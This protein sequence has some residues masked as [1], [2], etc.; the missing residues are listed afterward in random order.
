[1][2]NRQRT[3]DP[4]PGSVR[5]LLP[6]FFAF[7]LL[8]LLCAPPAVR[9]AGAEPLPYEWSRPDDPESWDNP[10]NSDLE[11]VPF[12]LVNVEGK[13]P[14]IDRESEWN[15]V[16]KPEWPDRDLPNRVTS[17]TMMLY[18]YGM[19][20]K[21][22]WSHVWKKDLQGLPGILPCT[23]VKIAG[24]Y[25]LSAV[26]QYDDTSME[27]S[28]GFTVSGPGKELI[29]DVIE[30]AAAENKVAGDPWQTAFNLYQWLLNQLEYDYTYSYH[31]SDAILRH[32][33]VCDSYARLYF[34]LCRAAGLDAYVIYGD[35]RMAYHAWTAVKIGDKWYYAD[36]TWDDH[37]VNDPAMGEQPAEDGNG[38]RYGV[39]DYRYFMLDRHL[40]TLND[41]LTCTW[42][43]DYKWTCEEQPAVSLDG[44]YYVHTGR[45]AAWGIAGEDGFRTVRDLIREAFVSGEKL[46]SSLSLSGTPLRTRGFTDPPFCLAATELFLLSWDLKG[47]SL[48]LQDGSKVVLDT[49]LYEAPDASGWVLN[50]YPEGS[51]ETDEPMR[52]ELSPGLKE[53]GAQAFEGNPHF[54]EVICLPGL[55]SIGSRAFACCSRLWS[56]RIPSDV[57]SIADDAFEGCGDFCIWTERREDS[58]PAR[59]AEEHGIT[60]FVDDEEEGGNG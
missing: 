11:T 31:S 4:V 14:G 45:C 1:M 49:Y 39:S 21:E 5:K 3:S 37:P 2:K 17:V 30:Q 60:L 51:P 10:D 35:T 13:E 55:Q 32:T 12:R 18:C 9:T 59:Y 44:N 47:S 22:N 26:V 28:A 27:I 41:H 57:I 23:G 36:P 24:R 6:V 46:W 38:N 7:V 42:L 8:L 56:V 19:D 43:N 52:I 33:G 16:L 40:M 50:V 20:W 15:L 53:I 34:M 48:D 29:T 54:G 25:I 58:V